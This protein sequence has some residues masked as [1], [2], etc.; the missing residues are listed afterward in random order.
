D[1]GGTALQPQGTG[2]LTTHYSGTVAAVWDRA[3]GTINFSSAGTDAVAAN[4]GSWQPMP[5]GVSGSAPANYGAQIS[6]GLFG[7]GRA[8]LR[9]THASL[10]TSTP[11][12]LTGTGPYTFAS[13]QTVIV[14]HGF[15]DYSASIFG[16]GREDLSGNS[17]N[18]TSATSGTL[19]DLG[20]GNYRVTLP[21]DVTITTTV[22]GQTAHLHILGTV[23]GNATLPA[24]DLN[25]S[26]SGADNLAG[27][28]Q[29]GT[30]VAIAP[31]AT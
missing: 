31:N 1:L 13:T 25:G 16:S 20:N 3:A 15:A 24:V 2:S 28:V 5:N 12:S 4:S 17:A 19:A 22:S 11:L 23:V 30:S 21:F 10:S 27:F 14:T 18:N 7:T 8:A 29:G 9:E 6:L 26:D